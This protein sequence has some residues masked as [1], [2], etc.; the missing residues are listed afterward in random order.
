M[1]FGQLI[2]LV[3]LISSS[4]APMY[5][6]NTRNAPLFRGQ[7]QFQG[8]AILTT[9]VEVQG[10]YALTDHLGI[11]GSYSLLSENRND[12]QNTAT[13]FKRKNNYYEAGLGWYNSTRSRRVE[14][15]AGYG[16]GESTTTGQ[17]IFLG[18]GQQEVIV[19]GNFKKYFIQPSIG[20]NNRGFNLSFTPRISFV[21]FYE[22]TTGTIPVEPDEKIALFIEPAVTAKFKLTPNLDGMF[23]LGLNF[24]G[25]SE[26]FFDHVPVQAGFGIQLHVGGSLK[27]KV[28]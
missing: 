4:C 2:L 21:D 25:S 20:T 12:P 11:I 26:V 17:Y 23:Q 1:R 27:T 18:L 22:F 14:L 5:I 3:A 6:P 16:Q 28:Y 7:G 13:T 19:T 9:G 24:P 15:Y 8:S 10:A